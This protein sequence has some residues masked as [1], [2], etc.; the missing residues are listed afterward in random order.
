MNYRKIRFPF[1]YVPKILLIGNGFNRAFGL[2]PSAE[3]L[4]MLRTKKDRDDR[5]RSLENLPFPLRPIALTSDCVD[6]R[7][8]DI[9]GE[10]CQLS[11]CREEADILRKYAALPFDAILTTNYTYEI[12]RSVE[13]DFRVFPGKTCKHRKVAVDEGSENHKKKFSTYYC[14]DNIRPTIWHI[15]GEAARH[16]TMIIG[17]YFYGDLLSKIQQ[18]VEPLKSGLAIC[19]KKNLDVTVSSWVDLFLLGEVHIIGFAMDVSEMDLWWLVNC[20]KRNFPNGRVFFYKPDIKP[21]EELI[22]EA[23]GITVRKDGYEN[24]YK[25]YYFRMANLLSETVFDKNNIT[26]MES[27]NEKERT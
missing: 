5:E 2:L 12:E 14:F 20:K 9:S 4:D 25:D 3:L 10:L 22:A 17:H 19:K 7:M 26:E 11:P 27:S 21:E 13:P 6:E 24:I 15:H 1:G 16:S 8:K 18:S 23:M